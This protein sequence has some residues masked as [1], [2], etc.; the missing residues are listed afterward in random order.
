MLFSRDAL[1]SERATREETLHCTAGRPA[2]GPF[3]RPR[4]HVGLLGTELVESFD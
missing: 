3:W 4:I 1:V 2:L